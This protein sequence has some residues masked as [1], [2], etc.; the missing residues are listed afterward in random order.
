MEDPEYIKVQKVL[1]AANVTQGNF[2]TLNMAGVIT[3]R[4][5]AIDSLP[6]RLL[7]SFVVL[8]DIKTK[9]ESQ[10]TLSCSNSSREATWGGR[11]PAIEGAGTIIFELKPFFEIET[12]D[13]LHF[14]ILWNGLELKHKEY[15][16]EIGKAPRYN[17]FDSP[18]PTTGIILP[19]QNFDIIEFLK[20]ATEELIIVDRY[21][22]DKNDP[23]FVNSLSDFLTQNTTLQVKLL[24]GK[25]G[26]KPLTDRLSTHTNLEMKF[27]DKI[28]DRFIIIN[29]AKYYIF[30]NSLKHLSG[31]KIS[32]CME[33]LESSQISL[34]QH[35]FENIWIDG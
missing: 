16:I 22:Y 8:S 25:E 35:E 15:K 4:T 28:H 20:L 7:G 10:I 11:V 32:T 33:I 18:P 27:S 9:S 6:Y 1:F 30:G 12:L 34:L 2:G 21:I 19:N 5:I 3:G 31:A 17:V 26:K 23:T 13:N 24:T 29:R 14:K